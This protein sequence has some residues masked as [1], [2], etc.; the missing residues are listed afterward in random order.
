M[1]TLYLHIGMPK[2]GTSSIQKFL[3]SNHLIL[4]QHGYVFPKLPYQYPFIYQNRNAYFMI[5]KQ[6]NEDDSRNRV[7]EKEI[8]KKGMETVYSYFEKY[9][10][11]ILSEE[12]L[13]RAFRTHRYL[14][15]Y[16]RKH[17]KNHGY[18]I[19]IIVYLR[20]QDEYQISLWKQN[21]KHPKTAQTL[22]FEE[23]LNEVMTKEPFT[24]QYADTL[25]EIS[26]IFG[27]DNLIVRRYDR[28][29]WKN[30]SIVDDFLDCIGLTHTAEYIDLPREINTSLSENMAQIKR[31]INKEQS[32]SKE[33]NAFLLQFMRDLSPESEKQ[34]PCSMLSAD[35]TR[36]FLAQFTEGNDRVAKEYLHDEKPLFSTEI[37]ELEKWNPDNPYMIEDL[38]RFFS[39]VSMNLRR[40]NNRLQDELIRTRTDLKRLNE[41]ISDLRT[42]VKNEQRLF[43][44]FKYKLKH[45][46]R[47]ILNR[48]F[49]RS[50]DS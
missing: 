50:N 49:H 23:R 15:P 30:E 36:A 31:I 21:V 34:Y 38:I 27:R 45:P 5:G 32:F 40:E 29:F 25:D 10:N 13:W 26:D 18:R 48:I 17:A 11:I 39:A 14:F 46:F 3:L 19:Q 20:R 4:E 28:S 33:E 37:N 9:D 22:P 24:L 16:L 8:L 35:E 47:A 6:Y 43:R 41:E 42:V 7:L 12:T 2:T 1:K 44:L